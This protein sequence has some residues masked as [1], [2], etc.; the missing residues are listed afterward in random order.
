MRRIKLSGRERAVI[1]TIGFADAI[2]GA[3][4]REHTQIPPDDLT[5]ILNGLIGAGYVESRPYHDQISSTELAN[6]EFEVN[7]SYVHELKEAMLRA[8]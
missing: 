6:T 2:S 8:W 5:D 4:I 1:K 7:P 3:Q